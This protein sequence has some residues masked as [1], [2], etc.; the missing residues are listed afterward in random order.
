M[1]RIEDKLF[2]LKAQNK[3]ALV[4]FITAGDPSLAET[5]KLI[6]TLEK[7]GVDII[8][9]GVPF[10]DPMAD[11]PVIQLSSERALSH[12]VD[13]AKI[14]DMVKRVRVKTQI[15]ILLM[16]YLNPIFTMGYKKF[17]DVAA[18]SGVDAVLIVDMPPEESGEC[19]EFFNKKELN[20]I[21]LLAPTSD[22]DRIRKVAKVASGFIYYVSLTG[23]TGAQ[24]KGT[25]EVKEQ[26]YKI[27]QWTDTPII[28]GFGISKPE[29]VKLLSQ[30][31]DGV[32]VGSALVKLIHENAKN[33]DLHTKV[34]KYLSSLK[35]ALTSK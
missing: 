6:L 13:L 24:L 27:R 35:Q 23:V 14:F 28:V 5:E 25:D 32:V 3:K 26:I 4:A 34:T 18:K 9:L 2:E 17:A 12:G 31:A 20:Q 8:E 30:K 29:Q 21:F 16:G 10:S 1:S 15:P 19:Q 33:K 11:G 22:E 7:A